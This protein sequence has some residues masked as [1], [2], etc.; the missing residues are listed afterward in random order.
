[1]TLTVDLGLEE[2]PAKN[3]NNIPSA[4]LLLFFPPDFPFPP[5][6]HFPFSGRLCALAPMFENKRAT[7]E[8]VGGG[9]FALRSLFS[10]PLLGQSF[11]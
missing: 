2:A 10:L 1:V 6:L 11:F 3:R 5:F 8:R 4:Q 9:T 7:R